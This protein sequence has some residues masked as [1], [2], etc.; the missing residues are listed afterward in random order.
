MLFAQRLD[1]AIQVRKVCQGKEEFVTR[2]TMAL[3]DL[4]VNSYFGDGTKKYSRRLELRSKDR[5]KRRFPLVSA[6]KI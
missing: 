3:W 6:F 5:L 2:E 4:K 1:L